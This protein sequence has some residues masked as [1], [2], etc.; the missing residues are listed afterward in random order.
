[1]EIKTIGASV[2][3]IVL[4]VVLSLYFGGNTVVEKTVEVR[5]GKPFGALAGP[6]I[7]YSYLNWGG[8]RIEHRGTPFAVAT[9]SVCSLQSPAA[10]STLLAF[11]YSI[12]TGT[13]T[14][15]VVDVGTSTTPF[16]T[17]TP[18]ALIVAQRAIASGAQDSAY[19]IATTSVAFASVLNLI[20]PNTY[21]NMKTGA[22][23]AG[24]T[25]GGSCGAEFLVL[26]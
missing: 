11:M 10:T 1:M 5:D 19:Y 13:S 24:Y 15:A 18:N 25:W 23:L 4:A 26:P 3:T 20:P 7:P 9:T 6:D 8:A 17:S 21:L 12:T 2:V 14:A 22:G 16:A